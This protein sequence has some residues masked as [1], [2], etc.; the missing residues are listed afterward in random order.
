MV[1]VLVVIASVAPTAAWNRPA[2]WPT[3]RRQPSTVTVTTP[4]TIIRRSV[5]PAGLSCASTPTIPRC[6]RDS[7][8]PAPIRVNPSAVWSAIDVSPAIA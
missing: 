2:R 6:G 4:S 1:A 5:A 8:V 7:R 3:T